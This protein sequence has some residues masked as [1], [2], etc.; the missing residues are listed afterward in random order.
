MGYPD[1]RR[2]ASAPIHVPFFLHENTGGAVPSSFLAGTV[3]KALALAPEVD[4]VPRAP[5]LVDAVPGVF[6]MSTSLSVLDVQEAF[7]GEKTSLLL[8]L[9]RVPIDDGEGVAGYGHPGDA[10]HVLDWRVVANLVHAVDGPDGPG[11]QF[12]CGALGV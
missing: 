3:L 12:L 7:A 11:D 4:E 10:H 9:A 6:C 8:S 5:G 2:R 1:H